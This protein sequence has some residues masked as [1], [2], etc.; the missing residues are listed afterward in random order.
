MPG[1]GAWDRQAGLRVGNEHRLPPS[2]PASLAEAVLGGEG[3]KELCK[4]VF[5]CGTSCIRWPLG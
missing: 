5:T 4:V 3:G 2:L 1:K